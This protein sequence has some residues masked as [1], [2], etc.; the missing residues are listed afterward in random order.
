MKKEK[1]IIFG[2]NYSNLIL[3]I[4]LIFTFLIYFQTTNFNFLAWDD[5]A[6]IT[7]NKY[8]TTLSYEN[9][10]HNLH[11]ERY[12]FL[13]LLTYS[14]LYQYFG[15]NPLCYHLL[16][17]LLQLLNIVLI[18]ILL[19]RITDN[20]KLILA[21]IV[22]FAL[23]PLRVESV[24]WVSELKDLMFSFFSISGLIYYTYYL[25]SSKNKFFFISFFL[26]VLASFSKI[27][28]LAIPFTLFLFDYLFERK[29]SFLSILEK[30][31]II[32][33]IL[34]FF[35]LKGKVILLL[36]ISY[37][38]FFKD[39]KINI[40]INK[41]LLIYFVSVLVLL[42]S[43]YLFYFLFS[44][45]IGLWV[46]NPQ[47]INT[48]SIPERFLL[49]SYS[50][51]FYLL[52]FLLPINLN[53]VH[54]YP[55]RD[56]NGNLPFE[57]YYYLFALLIVITI[58]IFLIVKR[59]KVSKLIFFGW[60]F[61]LINISLVLHFIPIQGR[62][63][64]A[65][66]YSYFA[67]FGLIIIFSETT[68]KFL[69]NYFNYFMIAVFAVLS[70]LTYNRCEA[71]KNTKTLFTD[72][73]SKNNKVAFAYQSLGTVYLSEQNIDSAMFCFNTAVNI[74]KCDASAYFNRAFAYDF[75]GKN[76]SAISDFNKVLTCDKLN[77]YTALVYTSLGESYKK[78]GNDT[79]ALKYYNLAIKNDS[80]L[81]LAY[82]NR[83]SYFLNKNEFEKANSDLEK[84]LKLDSFNYQAYN[85]YGWLLTNK[86]KYND[87]INYYNK[88][89]EINNNYSFTYNNKAY[90]EFLL[91]EINS[92]LL[93]YNKAIKINPYFTQ[94]YLNR[95][96]ALAFNKDYKSAIDD[97]NFVIKY[98]NK[99]QLAY[100]NR[101]HAYF[102]L[103][104]YRK[105]FEE[106]KLCTVKFPDNPLSWQNLGW[107]YMQVKDYNNSILNF[108]KSISLDSNLVNSY[109]NI[110]WIYFTKNNLK[111]CEYYYLKGY[112]IN[113]K[114]PDVLFLLGDLYKKQN[115]K[116]LACDYYQ[117]ASKL[118]NAN[119]TKLLNEYC[120]K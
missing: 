45:K 28:A 70:I 22:I 15:S 74:D 85:N 109:L 59:N 55:I 76:D 68:L 29:I 83:G 113:T 60:F 18:Y 49:A 4:V 71:W 24:A 20:T 57:L 88:S 111:Q 13:P 81:S 72:V 107:Y 52:N 46:H 10:S 12:T 43:I 98:D 84:A 44:N 104:D 47:H 41:K 92:A 35:Q 53:A 65:D 17:I 19:Y 48:F 5:N 116:D 106:F 63:V 118:G 26:F 67:Y 16:N 37:F 27:Q 110:G 39:K 42:V 38:I 69:K 78:I 93:D 108:N 64:V 112:H 87:A 102:S 21:S 66:R 117:K 11:S 36:F 119:A 56:I 82:N 58:S 101:A 25:K 61:F 6:Q 32:I 75:I 91:N 7:N 34:L 94:A 14:V 103:G 54:P 90:T 62:L 73:I 89:L 105:A 23:H 96:W 1:S 79:L 2:D 33:F 50:I 40:I 9:I 100:N 97:F 99:N 95:G 51:T 30:V 77:L 115:K 86:T 80:S 31:V 8:V 114:N 3:F 120:N